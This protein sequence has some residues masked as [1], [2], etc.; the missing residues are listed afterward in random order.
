MK[1]VIYFF[2]MSVIVV[3]CHPKG[4]EKTSTNSSINKSSAQSLRIAFEEDD[5]TKL[6]KINSH[7][8]ELE[9]EQYMSFMTKIYKSGV[10][11]PVMN[12]QKRPD[13]STK[14][15]WKEMDEKIRPFLDQNKEDAD[16]S[17]LR[18]FCALSVI[19]KT[20]ILKD[21]SDDALDALGYYIDI[22]AQEQNISPA[23]F[24][25]G[26]KKL[27]NHWP[28]QK[29]ISTVKLALSASEEA[30][31]QK[32]ENTRNMEKA[33]KDYPEAK[34]NAFYIDQMQASKE[35]DRQYQFYI[36][37]MKAMI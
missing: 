14:L 23:F 31:R 3:A 27:K 5:L 33:L 20:D 24:Y 2:I 13:Y 18:Q 30:I 12:S 10:L 15:L 17:Y 16:Y 35:I 29:L 25:H 34:N 9:K 1:T 32:E 19:A 37:Q 7:G 11:L 36:K 28:K 6:M 8:K 26:F 4:I 21:N 22:L